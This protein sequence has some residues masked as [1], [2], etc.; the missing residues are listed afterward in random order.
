V[1]LPSPASHHRCCGSRTLRIYL[2][3][4]CGFLSFIFLFKTA[5]QHARSLARATM[6]ASAMAQ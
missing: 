5:R 4:G 2:R 6:A 3:A 1:S